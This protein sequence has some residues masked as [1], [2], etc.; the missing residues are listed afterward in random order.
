[1]C[2]MLYFIELKVLFY[3]SKDI[4]SIFDDEPRAFASRVLFFIGVMGHAG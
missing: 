3:N 2:V 1:M 4:L